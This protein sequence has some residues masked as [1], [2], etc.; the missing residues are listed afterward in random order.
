MKQVKLTELKVG[1]IVLNNGFKNVLFKMV[2]REDSSSMAYDRDYMLI[3]LGKII[4]YEN[5]E[6]N[7]EELTKLS[8]VVRLRGHVN[9]TVDLCDEDAPFKFEQVSITK[10]SRKQLKTVSYYE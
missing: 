8:Y 4:G 6:L 10:I 3:P 5:G 7:T 9:P 1:D 2:N